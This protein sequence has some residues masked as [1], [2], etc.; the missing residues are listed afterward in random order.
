MKKAV[1]TGAS[2]YIGSV[3][4]KM[5]AEE[6]Y[7]VIGIDRN[8][9]EKVSKYCTF[10]QFDYGNIDPNI[11]DYTVIFHLGASSLLGPSA[12]NPLDYFENN[13]VKSTS[14]IRYALQARAK[15]IFASTAAVYAPYALDKDWG[16]IDRTEPVY[17]SDEIDPPN[18]YG[19]S[20]LMTEQMLDAV[21]VAHDW[22]AVS[23][24]FFNVIGSYGEMGPF[25]HTPHV[26]SSSTC[27]AVWCPICC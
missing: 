14:I 13:T 24:R 23:F 1:V 7:K 8:F 22:T 10:H 11:D 16:A 18:N 5:L 21:C 2:G 17:E 9:S 27:K 25:K 26:L 20:K 19:K 6:G 12:T 4:V 3:L 15:L